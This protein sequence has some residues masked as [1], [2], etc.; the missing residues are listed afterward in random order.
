MLLILLLLPIALFSQATLI[1]QV[2]KEGMCETDWVKEVLSEVNYEEIQ[3][4]KWSVF[5]D[6]SIIVVSNDKKRKCKKYLDKLAKMHYKFAVIQ[7]S[8]EFYSI[9]ADF[10]EQCTFVLRHYWHER[11]GKNVASFPLGYKQG[12]LSK[13]T[14]LEIKDA[15][16][17]KYVWSFAGQIE[18]STRIAMIESMKKIPHYYIHETKQFFDPNALP[19]DKY[20]ELLLNSIFIPCP[21]GWANLESFRVYEALECGCIPIVEKTEIDYFEKVLGNYPFLSLQSWDEA[22]DLIRALLENPMAL[23]QMRNK[24]K[25]WWIDYK[26]MM[27][28]EIAFKIQ[29]HLTKS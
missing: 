24:C 10:Y 17:R 25:Q 13:E 3:D 29:H 18:K 15:S 11:Y 23:E 4:G 5:K 21:R 2:D 27:K 7:L 1:W 9:P 6:N 14:S 16:H 28:K 8:D 26:K 12:F 22:P 20:R 19:S